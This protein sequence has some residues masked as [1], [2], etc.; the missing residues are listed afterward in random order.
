MAETLVPN[1]D[2]VLVPQA[3]LPASET[4]R[5]LALAANGGGSGLGMSH[6]SQAS[7]CGR[8]ARLAAERN[9]HFASLDSSSLPSAKN[10][11]VI[12]SVMHK[13]HELA[14]TKHSHTL[15]YSEQFANLNVAEGVRLYRGW[16]RH[17]GLDFWG[18]TL[19]VEAFLEDSETFASEQYTESDERNTSPTPIPVTGAIDM[20]VDMDE[21][22]CERARRR[23]LNLQPGRRIVDWKSADGPSDG[24]QYAGGLQALW[25]PYLWNLHNPEQPVD[26]IIFDVVMKRARRKD[27]TVLIDDFQAFYVPYGMESVD[28]LRGMVQ[29]GHRNITDDIPNRSEC[30]SWRGEVCVFRTNGACNAE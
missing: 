4:E 28:A 26:G 21:A 27:R 2:G 7:R 20:V 1:E 19:A 17:W 16:L 24:A 22:A 6:Y 11:F 10:H 14:R 8:K 18:E 15:D 29:Q 12:G 5:V 9:A 13:L 23:G 25:Y 30:V 3:T